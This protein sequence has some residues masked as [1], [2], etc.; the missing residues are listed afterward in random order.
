MS[1]KVFLF[2]DI[3]VK[4]QFFETPG[5]TGKGRAGRGKPGMT[6]KEERHDGE[7]RPGMTGKGGLDMIG[8]CEI[9]LTLRNFL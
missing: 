7:N 1:R 3:F 2:H 8:N 4:L 6:G 5:R 9:F